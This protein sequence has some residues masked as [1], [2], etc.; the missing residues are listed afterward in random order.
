MS[1]T[2]E[3]PSAVSAERSALSWSFWGLALSQPVRIAPANRHML[4]SIAMSFMECSLI[5]GYLVKRLESPN[6]PAMNL[7]ISNLGKSSGGVIVKKMDALI[8]KNAG[9][10][11][12]GR[13]D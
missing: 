1:A 10:T 3:F 11:R 6:D 9:K 5:V 12:V 7:L 8:L 2:I 4:T 13:N